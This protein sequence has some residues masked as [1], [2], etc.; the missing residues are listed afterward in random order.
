MLQV[1]ASMMI[2][3][4]GGVIYAECALLSIYGHTKIK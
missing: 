3:G 4:R 2:A 1:W